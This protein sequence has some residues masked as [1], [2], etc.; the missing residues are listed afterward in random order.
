M[1]W[2]LSDA[3][4]A[5]GSMSV[6]FHEAMDQAFKYAQT[7][8]DLKSE[9]Q[10]FVVISESLGSF[11]I[12]DAIRNGKAHVQRLFDATYDLYF[13]ANQVAMLELGRITNL[14][15]PGATI[16]GLGRTPSG[17]SIISVLRE[18]ASRKPLKDTEEL[19][20]MAR[21]G[22]SQ[23]IAF[24]DPSDMLTYD[25]PS[26]QGI[27]VV[28]VY[29]RNGCNFLGLFENPTVAHTGHMDNADVR[30]ILFKPR[31]MLK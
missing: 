27:T 3:V 21:P 12:L 28:N 1:N 15:Q 31:Q 29:D 9:D 7:F 20:A 10:E 2:G 30:N 13:L 14:M 26:I 19:K 17:I 25:M 11:V 8:D 6:F 23:V 24:N 22:K 18:W 4:L 16:Q 5:V